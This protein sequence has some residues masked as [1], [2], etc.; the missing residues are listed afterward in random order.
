MRYPGVSGR[1]NGTQAAMNE[2]QKIYLRDLVKSAV[3]SAL[4]ASIWRLPVWAQV[5]VVVVGGALVLVLLA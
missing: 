5:A 4:F 2:A 3:Q 1:Y